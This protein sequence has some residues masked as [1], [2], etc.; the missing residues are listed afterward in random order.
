MSG[1]DYLFV[2]D[3]EGG[4]WLKIDSME[5]LTDYFEHVLPGKYDGAINL[6]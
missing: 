2:F 1:M 3:D 6:Y 5:K 4:W